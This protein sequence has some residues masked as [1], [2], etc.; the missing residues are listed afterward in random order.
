MYVKKIAQPHRVEI[1]LS[2]HHAPYTRWP[3]LFN[4]SGFLTQPVLTV[5]CRIG[6]CEVPKVVNG[7]LQ[8]GFNVGSFVNHG[9]VLDYR[10]SDGFTNETAKPQCYNGTWTT[11]PVCVPGIF[12]YV[13]SIN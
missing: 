7:T 11:S 13:H 10:C 5:W 4:S 1:G 3:L 2:I 6:K 9:N 8:S 12:N